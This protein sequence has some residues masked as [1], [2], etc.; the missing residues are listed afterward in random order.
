MTLLY[1]RTLHKLGCH[2][3]GTGGTHIGFGPHN[4]ILSSYLNVKPKE[5]FTRT[6]I[7]LLH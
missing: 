4:G 7:L 2:A 3:S 1:N 6:E 5:D